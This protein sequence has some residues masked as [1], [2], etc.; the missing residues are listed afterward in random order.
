MPATAALQFAYDAPPG[1]DDRFLKIAWLPLGE[2]NNAWPEALAS[3]DDEQ[4]YP[5]PLFEYLYRVRPRNADL[6]LPADKPSDPFRNRL[7]ALRQQAEDLERLERFGE[8]PGDTVDTDLYLGDAGW[9]GLRT[10][11]LRPTTR[12]EIRLLAALLTRGPQTDDELAADLKVQANLVPRL[13]KALGRSMR[14]VERDG[15]KVRLL[16][17]DAL[18]SV[19]FVLRA[20]M[21][22]NPLEA[23]P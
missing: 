20:K 21:G 11:A 12:D 10:L 18:G 9:P 7:G 1:S 8:R 2:R 5:V 23:L 14:Q 16:E 19:L 6:F 4:S 22:L 17:D 15:R 3:V 13:A